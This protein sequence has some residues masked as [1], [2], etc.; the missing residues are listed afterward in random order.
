M[1]RFLFVLLVSCV[2]ANVYAAGDETFSRW[3]ELLKQEASEQGISTQ[4]IDLTLKDAEFLPSVIELDR[5]QPEFISTFT[6]YLNKRVTTKRLVQGRL[7]LKEHEELLADIEKQYG[8]PKSILVAFWGLETNYGGN[9]GNFGLPSTLMTLAYEGRRADFFRSQLIDVMR[10]VDAGH[11]DISGMRGSWA[12]AMGHMQFMPSTFL[13]YAIDADADGRNNIWTSLPDA[14]SSAANYLSSI[15]W[16]QGEPVALEVKLPAG[17]EYYQA[18]LDFR[19]HSQNW[20]ALGVKQ[21]NGQ[22]LPNLDH[23]ALLLP[24]G[25]QGPAFLVARN[26]DVVMKWNRSVNYAI[27][28]SYLADQLL[29][30]QPLRYGLETSER[31]ITFDQA[32]ALQEKLNALGYDS[33]TPD[34]LPGTKTKRAIRSYQLAN[35]L[36]ADGYP[37]M[38]LVERIMKQK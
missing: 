19:Q 4:T 33:G 9:K 10:I 25:W 18:Q 22:A 6:S 21:A 37:S 8:V 26:F 27:S 17:F 16:Q 30:N 20:R 32:W 28:V 31:G 38:A 23:S 7:A 24:Q 15:G 13:A 2:S 36:P 14:F 29:S 35:K 3:L 1:I 34:G 11:N 5:S 12:G